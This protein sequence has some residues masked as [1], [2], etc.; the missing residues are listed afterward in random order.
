M[1]EEQDKGVAESLS[2]YVSGT[3]DSWLETR[4]HSNRLIIALLVLVSLP[5]IAIGIATTRTVVPYDRI[6]RTLEYR[7]AILRGQ[8]TQIVVQFSCAQDKTI[9]AAFV[10]SSVELTLSDGRHLTLPQTISASGARFAN[11]DESF[12]FWTKGDTAFVDE[13]Q[14]ETYTACVTNS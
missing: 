6:V 3:F 10:G 5:F 14:I 13:G 8:S 1:P 11:Q 4:K 7:T 12:I 2:D 9:T